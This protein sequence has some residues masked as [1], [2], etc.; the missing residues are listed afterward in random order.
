MFINQ[1]ETTDGKY[2][3]FAVGNS[4]VGITSGATCT[5]TAVFD[6]AD[7]ATDSTFINDLAARNFNFE[8][9][10]DGIVDFSESNPFGDAT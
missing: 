9:E 10:A 2:H 1:I 7:S 5:V 3:T 6:V 8:T 4:L